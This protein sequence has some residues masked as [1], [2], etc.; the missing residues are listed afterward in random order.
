MPDPSPPHATRRPSVLLL[1]ALTGL[2][3]LSI[4]MSLPAMPQL[5]RTFGAGVGAVQLTL[6]LFLAGFAAGQLVCGV[7]ADRIGRRPV[8]LAGLA[9][10]TA[11][12]IACA[13]SPSLPVLVGARLV[14]GLGASVGPILA[15]AIVRDC[16]ASRE[17]S[18]VL[19]QITQ[20]MIA[21]P[22]VAPTAGSLLLTAFD[23]LAIFLV[24]GAAG[25]VLWLVAWRG[26]RETLPAAVR[27]GERV[28][29]LRSYAAVLTHRDS[30]RHGLTT[31]FSYGGMF[32]YISGSPFV[33]IDALGVPRTLFGVLFAL[34]ALALMVGATLNRRL[35]TRMDPALLLRRGVLAV[36]GAGLAL[37]VLAWL[38]IG[39]VPGVMVP[40]MAYMLGLGLVQ[41]NATAAALAPHGR[42][43]GVT[44]SLIGSAQTAAGAIS[45][46][47][48]GAFYDHT[49]R[50]LATTVA[51]AGILT[52]LVHDRRGP[53]RDTAEEEAVS[54][55]LVVE[56]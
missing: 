10:F 53:D 13:L 19:S 30:L 6:S 17:A 38:D 7:V 25:L 20:V 48:V 37:A 51:V 42:A 11:A 52:L 41:P 5:Q 33:L 27:H 18:G 45:G 22:I 26:L 15:R 39:G 35:V 34:P 29:L 9:L 16:F 49:P 50:S 46:S 8:L 23:W 14:Q 1:A 21:A 32:A 4:D 12:G 3:A 24:L 40:M 31:C 44:S 2:T 56:A 47:I 54:P 55:P 43:A 28:P 36:F